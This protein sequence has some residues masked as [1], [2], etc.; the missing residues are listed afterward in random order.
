MRVLGY[1]G[2]M[3]GY[4]ARFGSSHDAAAATVV[5]GQVVAACE[6]ERFTR[7][8]HTGKFPLKAIEF[9]MRSAGV[10][11]ASDLTLI[12]YYN[13]L[14]Q[15]FAPEMLDANRERMGAFTRLA[16]ATSLGFMRQ[17]NRLAGHDDDRP[18][19]VFARK[20]GAV[21]EP[22]RFRPVPHHLCH[23]ASAFYPSPFDEALC[24]TL[25]GQG[26]AASAMLSIGQGTRLRVLR[27]LYAPNSMGYLY[28]CMTRFLG[29][30]FGDDFKVMG[31]A[32]YGDPSRFRRYF[33]G[34]VR[35]SDDGSFS[36]DAT[37]LSWL[38][39]RDALFPN[40]VLYPRSMKDTLGPARL[41]DEPILQR[42]AD[43][44]AAL[45]E[46]LERVVLRMLGRARADT[47]QR[48]LCLAGGVALN[49]SMNG[50]IARSGLFDRVWVQ[51]AAH[52]A[53]TALGAAL[54]GYHALLKGERTASPRAPVYLGPEY[55][56]AATSRAILGL[57]PEIRCHRPADLFGTVARALAEGRIV[58]WFHGRGEWGPRALGHRSILADPR[59][60]E[61]KDRVNS[62]VKLREGFRP[63]APACLAEHAAEWF[64]LQGI[65]ESP[66][67]LF[68]APVHEPKRARIPA[69]TH[70]DGTARVQ[71]V[72]RED[73]PRFHAL[74]R[75]F[76]ELTGVPMLLN[77][78]FNVNGEPIVCSPED[79][80]RCFLGTGIDLLIVE[81]TAIEKRAGASKRPRP[82]PPIQAHLSIGRTG[83]RASGADGRGA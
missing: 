38:I 41:P 66:Y 10:R 53:G 24:F 67:M 78:S 5:D 61:M 13:C 70:V 16:Y 9:C 27:Q 22:G 36:V 65:G 74:L 72:A 47:G 55:G 69:V 48:D 45:Q 50:K 14:S 7:E 1:N 19:R 60:P 73:S 51:P 43:V 39:V 42:H 63:F 33:E 23:A 83:T 58:G 64:D 82:A 34:L 20:M 52:D 30:G 8:K 81:D 26:E 29:F 12:C 75:A 54:Y 80:I 4:P 11:D 68:A 32:P 57:G 3:D 59:R 71:T 21:P 46:A 6:E 56:A 25:D 49:C 2:G 44:A 18:Q 40:G 17:Y 79:A 15:M 28:G 77:T 62:A 35:S 37:W 76:H 31:L